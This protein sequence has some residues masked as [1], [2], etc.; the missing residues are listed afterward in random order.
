MAR[1]GIHSGDSADL[2]C[3]A[4]KNRYT[5]RDMNM[6]RNRFMTQ[7]KET[8]PTYL[9]K[10]Y[11]SQMQNGID[12]G[13]LNGGGESGSGHDSPGGYGNS[14]E[15]NSSGSSG[16]SS[17]SDNSGHSGGSGGSSGHGGNGGNGGK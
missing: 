6:M 5:A 10:Q 9:A 17:G 2:V 15:S 16:G 7:Y 12:P 14:G 8:N 13:D 3:E 4:L 11:K 1:S